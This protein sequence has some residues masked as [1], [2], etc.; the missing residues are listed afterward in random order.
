MRGAASMNPYFHYTLTEDAYNRY[1]SLLAEQSITVHPLSRS[2]F[3]LLDGSPPTVSVS[4]SL[5]H[6]GKDFTFTLEDRHNGHQLKVCHFE[7]GNAHAERIMKALERAF[8]QPERGIL[9]QPKPERSWEF[10][11]IVAPIACLG[12]LSLIAVTCFF[13]VVGIRSWL[14]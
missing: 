14:R 7:H 8:P 2:T 1:E 11:P 6:E 13:A 9:R 5:R 12:C 3:Q 4:G 10:G